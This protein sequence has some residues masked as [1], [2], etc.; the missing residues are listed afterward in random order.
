M[1]ES[2]IQLLIA[3][4]HDLVDIAEQRGALADKIDSMRYF[5]SDIEQYNEHYIGIICE[6]VSKECNEILDALRDTLPPEA[7]I[8]E[9]VPASERRIK[10]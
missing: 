1:T 7:P 5:L 4:T 3:T 10:A 6:H 2:D 9:V 8:T